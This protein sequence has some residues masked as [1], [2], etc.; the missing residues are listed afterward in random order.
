MVRQQQAIPEVLGVSQFS[1]RTL[2]FV[3]QLLQ[4]WDRKSTRASCPVSLP[5][6]GESVGDEAMNPVF[7]C[8]GRVTEKMGCIIG[9]RA[10]EDV[11]DDIKS[12]KVAAFL[13]SGYFVLNCGDKSLCIW[14]TYPFHREQPPLMFAPILLH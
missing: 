6:S 4:V 3:L 1:G 2:D 14:N 8:P 13:G 9:A 5:Q 11:Q 7:N 10:L 12:M